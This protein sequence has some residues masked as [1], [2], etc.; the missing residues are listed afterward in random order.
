VLTTESDASGLVSSLW[1][2]SPGG[3]VWRF[4]PRLEPRPAFPVATGVS[5]TMPPTMLGGSLALFSK[6]DSAIVLIGPD[7]SR[8][9]LQQRLDA[10]LYAPPDFQAGRMAFYPRSFDARVYLSDPSG[11]EAPGWPVRASGISSCSPRIVAVGQS[12]IIAFLTQAGVLHAWDLAGNEAAR[13]PITLPGVYYATPQPT[14][15]DGRPA[16]VA[17]AQDGAL[18]MIG[19]DGKVLR[20]AAVPDL[21]GKSARIL[22]ADIDGS[23]SDEI[24]LYGSGAFI[25]GYDSSFRP[26]AGFPVKGVS[27]PQ[28][29]DLDR[30]GRID[31]VTA[32]IDG[33]IYAYTMTRTGR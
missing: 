26:L 17:L 24:F 9:T 5:S 18:S 16:L 30:D 11:V 28:L 8:T 19:L 15:V 2:V 12:F 14:A 4:G 32:G 31:F 7:G 25:E 27:R 3:T 13:F 21:D 1:A 10:P 23:G 33:R 29:V 20:Q 6:Q 22:T